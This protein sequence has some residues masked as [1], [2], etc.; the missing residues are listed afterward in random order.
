MISKE[1][2]VLDQK[3]ASYVKPTQ[4]LLRTIVGIGKT[5]AAALVA[6]VGDISRFPN[7]KK[8]AAYIGLDCHVHESGTSVLGKGFVTKRGNKH[9]R[10]LLFNA[11]FIAR[12]HDPEL[13]VYFE[14]KRGE[15]KHYFSAMCAVERKLIH[16][17]H[18][19]WK[20][21]TP[22]ELRESKKPEEVIP[23][24]TT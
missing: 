2:L 8:L 10:S 11:A 6:Y 1:I 14:K 12:R 18:A 21:G 13:K 5:S 15:G 7:P 17:I 9:L 20:R 3:M 24:P 4:A 16:R 22:F 23:R 19:V